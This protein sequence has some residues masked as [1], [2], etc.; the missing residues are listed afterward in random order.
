MGGASMKSKSKY[1]KSP[2]DHCRDYAYAL[3]EVNSLETG[4]IVLFSTP[5]VATRKSR[6]RWTSVAVVYRA[7]EGTVSFIFPE[8]SFSKLYNPIGM[9][10]DFLTENRNGVGG[11]IGFR[12]LLVERSDTFRGSFEAAWADCRD[13]K[14][15]LPSHDQFITHR[16]FRCFPWSSKPAIDM[17][18]SVSSEFV[19]SLFRRVGILE[20]THPHHHY[21]PADFSEI[22]RLPGLA[23]HVSLGYEEPFINFHGWMKLKDKRRHPPPPAAPPVIDPITTPMIFH[24]E[25]VVASP[26]MPTNAPASMKDP[27]PLMDHTLPQ[28]QPF[29]MVSQPNSF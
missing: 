29:S 15:D 4:D 20:T 9:I 12:R 7:T 16:L 18:S 2:P 19:A 22:R 21:S 5:E 13:S 28:T 10:S 6:S 26:E 8:A 17:K 23:P 3:A 25:G 1:W 24:F 11:A 27:S 14:L